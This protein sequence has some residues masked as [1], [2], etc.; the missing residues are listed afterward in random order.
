MLQRIILSGLFS[1]T[2]LL[3]I[4]QTGSIKGNIKDATSGDNIVGATVVLLGTTQGTV[5][6]VD[7]NFAFPKV[8]T[9]SYSLI[10]SFISYKSDTI[11]NITVYPDQA[12]VIN[13][14]LREQSQELGEVLITGAKLRNTDVSVITEIK[15]ADLVAVGISAQ[16]I[17][18]SQDRDA[19]QVLKRMP[20]VSITNNRFVNVRGLSERYSV[21][22]LNGVIAPS[23]EVDTRAFAFDLIPSNMIDRMMVYKSGAAELPGD[24][25]GAVIDIS[26]KSNVDENSLSVNVTG[27]YRTGTTFGDFSSYRGS[28]TDVLGFDNGKRDL[29]AT[30]PAQNLRSI[31]D[32]TV[33]KNA[34]ASLNNQYTPTSATAA[35]DLR[36]TINFARTFYLGEKKLSNVTSLSY[37]NTYQSYKQSNYYYNNGTLAQRYAYSDQLSSHAVRTGLIS[38]FILELNPSNKIEFHNLINQLGTSQVTRRGGQELVTGYDVKNTALNYLERGFYSGQLQG[39]HSLTNALN[40]KWVLGHSN[41]KSD[42]P[43][44]RRYRTQRPIGTEDGFEL[45]VPPTSSTF[46]GRFYSQLDEKVYTHAMNVELKLN[47]KEEQEEKQAKLQAGYYLAQTERSFNARWF[48][49]RQLRYD[50][51]EDFLA[52]PLETIFAPE[53]T[54]SESPVFSLE[55]GTG[56]TDEYAGKNTLV[57]GYASITVPFADKFRF[58]GGVRV[59]DNKQ[60]LNSFS[61]NGNELNV[62]NPVTSVLPFGNLSYNFTEKALVRIAYSKTVNRPMFREIAPFNYY[63]FERN[64]NFFGTPGLK[65][66]EINNID[67]RWEYYP[68][69]NESISIG[70]FYKDFTNPIEMRLAPGSNLLY[71]FMNAKSAVSYGLEVEARKSLSELTEIAFLQKLSLNMNAAIIRS[72]VKVDNSDPD[73]DNLEA[74][75]Y[76]Q[77]QSPYLVNL[78]LGYSDIE[79]G[80]QVNASYNVFGPRVFAVGDNDENPTQY[81][82][83]RHQV[84]L[85]ISKQLSNK[86]DAKL[87]IQDVLNQKYRTYQDQNRDQKISGDDQEI[88]SYR[89]GQYITL[90]FTYKLM[91]E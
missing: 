62:N 12:T 77:G 53:N 60:T 35:L 48:S 15:E 39:K 55:E 16:Q 58:S 65:V 43:D 26:T 47:P 36:T 67:L 6:D 19:S 24:F 34:G 89:Q 52:Q 44:Y 42:Q 21:V 81:E 69:R 11:K 7:G 83:P 14:T 84:D 59:E 86:W 80:L 32:M 4:A 63:D 1:L 79:T 85:T 72:N 33:I 25:A 9:G 8:K 41:F 64:A 74:N 73:F 10:V 38:N 57:A 82:L 50:V 46:D 31:N 75:R 68:N 13:T 28:S 37:S 29:P 87:G 3:A 56:F 90:G 66:A 71:T 61:T 22:L 17:S 91:G 20:G 23:T 5:A 18:M 88:F 40:V 2:A 51:A 76:M 45:V 30:F 49:F 70:G 54:N 78:G 27:G